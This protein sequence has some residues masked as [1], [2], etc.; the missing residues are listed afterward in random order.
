MS[1]YVRGCIVPNIFVVYSALST[2]VAWSTP[3]SSVDS[4]KVILLWNPQQSAQYISNHPHRI[5]QSAFLPSGRCGLLI[6]RSSCPSLGVLQSLL[7]SFHDANRLSLAPS[8]TPF[9]VHFWLLIKP[10]HTESWQESWKQPS[11]SHQ[12]HNDSLTSEE[13][14]HQ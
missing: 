2:P 9:N 5:V 4:V 11:V 8:S 12:P 6:V 13:V 14:R 10:T 1:G 3:V 7:V